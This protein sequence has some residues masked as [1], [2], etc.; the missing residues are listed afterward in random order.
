VSQRLDEWE[1]EGRGINGRENTKKQKKKNRRREGKKRKIITTYG[2]NTT[3]RVPVT[4]SSRSSYLQPDADV[5]L[6]TCS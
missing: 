6:I 5:I 1:G 4:G 2:V 3:K